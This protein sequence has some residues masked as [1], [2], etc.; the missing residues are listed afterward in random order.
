MPIRLQTTVRDTFKNEYL[1]VSRLKTYEKCPLAFKAHYIDRDIPRFS[2]KTAAAKG[3]VV[4]EALEFIYIWIQE[5]MFEGSVPDEVILREYR[6][7]YAKAEDQLAGLDTYQEGLELVRSY[8]RLHPHVSYLD[9]ISTEQPFS[10][11]I[12]DD[13]DE[14]EFEVQGVIDRIDAVDSETIRVVDYKTNKMLF[15]Q[16]QLQTD[17]Q[18]SCYG[19]VVQEM[20]PWAK[21]VEYAFDML[22]HGTRQVTYRTDDELNQAADYMIAI[23]RKIESATEFP[24][25]LGPLCSWCDY[26]ESCDEFKRALR[27]DVDDLSRQMV[28]GQIEDIVEERM[29]LNAIEAAAKNK[30]KALDQVLVSEMDRKETDELKVGGYSIRQQQS[31]E[32]TYPLAKTVELL[33]SELRLPEDE[34]LRRIASVGNGRM[35]KLIKDSQLP[36][37]VK[38]V[39]RSKLKVVGRRSMRAPWLRVDKVRG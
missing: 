12:A 13:E 17:L 26:R 39:I 31:G 1:S 19:I 30:R 15:T 4:H 7:A 38:R 36:S 18:M 27:M 20:F 9:V 22:R 25:K 23:G 2:D 3:K 34:V 37:G 28:S 8:F 11:R 5:E 29:R 32:T 33:S 6:K 21:K 16:H 35:E 10:L 14:Y 24:A